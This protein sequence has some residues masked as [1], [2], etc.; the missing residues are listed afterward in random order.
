MSFTVTTKHRHFSG[1]N[2]FCY[3][4]SCFFVYIF[5]FLNLFL[6][7]FSRFVFINNNNVRSLLEPFLSTRTHWRIWFVCVC[8]SFSLSQ[9][10]L[11]RY[12]NRCVG[13]ISPPS[14]LGMSLWS[15]WFW[16]HATGVDLPHL[17]DLRSPFCLCLLRP[18]FLKLLTEVV[19]GT[20][21]TSGLDVDQDSAAEEGAFV[22]KEFGSKEL[23]WFYCFWNRNGRCHCWIIWGISSADWGKIRKIWVY[24]QRFPR[25]NASLEAIKE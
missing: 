24:C 22:G 14:K 5:V 19:P 4:M 17:F 21:L 18:P 23:T 15:H 3:M 13:T 10:L 11:P 8:L 25:V 1:E 6:F 12:L 2:W 16:I 7:L 20:T 9:S